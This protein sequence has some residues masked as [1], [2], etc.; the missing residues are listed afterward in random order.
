MP[1]ISIAMGPQIAAGVHFAA[2]APGCRLAEYNPKVFTVANRFLRR[3]LELSGASYELPSA[4]G[5][6]VEVDEEGVR[7]AARAG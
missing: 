2:A 6:G 4:P 5:L 1:H 7:E 3:R